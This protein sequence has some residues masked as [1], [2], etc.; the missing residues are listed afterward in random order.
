MDAYIVRQPILNQDRKVVAYEILYKEDESSLY[1]PKDSRAANAIEQF[2]NDLNLE[3]FLGKQSAFI[4]FTPNLL[5][6]N[7]PRLF[8]PEKMV[9]QIDE[10]AIIHPVAQKMIYRYKKQGYSIALNNFEFN[11]RY[12]GIIDAIDYVKVD[13][14][15]LNTAKGEATLKNIVNMV[16]NF[17]KKVIAY[18]VNTEEALELSK[19]L[20]CDLTQGQY[21][22]EQKQ[23]KVHRVDHMQSNFFQLMVAVTKDEPDIQEIT[24]IIARDVT[25]AFSL[26]KLVNSAYFALRNQVTSVQQALVI[27]GLGQLKQWIYLLSFKQDNGGTTDELIKISFLRANFCME[28]SKY[29]PNLPISQSEAYMM[30]M[31]STLDILMEVPMDMVLSELAISEEIK[32]ALLTGEGICGALYHLV[33][34]YEKAD[35]TNMQKMAEHL[36]L[37]MNVISQIYFECVEYVNQIWHD[38]LKPK[39]NDQANEQENKEDKQ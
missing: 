8:A 7:I 37:P 2:L 13:F 3:K 15:Y 31:F 36:G 33:L 28:L 16:H 9:I 1:N 11:P 39:F 23:D 22:A 21:V 29:L 17:N 5:M 14:S 32:N 25:L 4:T 35:W 27:L 19:E 6:K 12:F 30:G 38:L 20:K 10:N 24:T 18:Q 26:M 34:C